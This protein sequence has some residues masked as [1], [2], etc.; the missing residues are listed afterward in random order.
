MPRVI[1]INILD[2][3]LRPEKGFHTL[4]FMTYFDNP[5][6]WWTDRLEVHDLQ[7]PIFRNLSPDFNNP[8]HLWLKALVESQKLKRPMREVIDMTPELREFYDH[9]AGFAQFVDRHGL[10]ASDPATRRH[11]ENWLSD[12]VLFKL[13]RRLLQAEAKVETMMEIA[14]IHLREAKSDEARR[15]A[16]EDLRRFRIPED[17]ITRAKELIEA[18]RS[19]ESR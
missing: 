6:E 14:L 5:G 15:A 9:D 7:L 2:F 19:S 11:Y 16:I 1:S 17:I 8:L 4:G 12:Q 18:E 13:E 3:V 10:V